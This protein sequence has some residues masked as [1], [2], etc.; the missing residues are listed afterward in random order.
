MLP[1]AVR[2]CP[3]VNGPS[4]DL[5]ERVIEHCIQYRQPS[6]TRPSILGDSPRGWSAIPATPRESIAVGTA[7]APAAR[8]ASAA[9]IRTSSSGLVFGG[10]V[11]G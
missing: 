7:G 2:R 3:A 10:A 1:P 6:R 9:G 4:G 5:V 11:G 8:M